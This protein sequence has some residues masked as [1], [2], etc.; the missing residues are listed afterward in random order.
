LGSVINWAA[1]SKLIG[2]FP[3]LQRYAERLRA[4]PAFQASRKD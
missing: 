3:A 2:D 1:M 4:R